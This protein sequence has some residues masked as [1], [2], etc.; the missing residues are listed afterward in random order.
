MHK[1]KSI[2]DETTLSNCF[3]DPQ[4]QHCFS[5]PL[6]EVVD[7]HSDRKILV[8][9]GNHKLKLDEQRNDRIYAYQFAWAY[10]VHLEE[11]KQIHKAI[12]E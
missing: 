11:N 12:L 3:K 9:A 10:N 5:I 7:D 8:Y 2:S 1:S 6:E 4:N